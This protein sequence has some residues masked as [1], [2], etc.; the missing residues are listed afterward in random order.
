VTARL[1]LEDVSFAY[2]AEPVLRGVT[3]EV[4]PAA[5][6]A[7]VGPNGAGKTT[8]LKIAAGLLRPTSGRVV[9]ETRAGGIAYLAQAEPLPGSFTTREIVEL[10]RFPHTGLLRRLSRADHA[11]VGAA[12]ELTGTT[13]L[14]ERDVGTLSGGEQQ[15]VAL[16]RALAQEPEVLL[17]DE[18]TNHL[19]PRHQIELF[20]ALRAAATRGVAVVAVL[21]DLAFAS[22]VDRCLLLASGALVAE[23]PPADVLRAERLSQVYGATIEVITS[24]TGRLVPVPSLR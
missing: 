11:A 8:L 22:A 24:P 23:G 14:A 19:D 15:R 9:V 16:A 7:I 21:H 17:L 3:F 1:G 4:A 13:A 12:L 2:E 5:I 18:P 10:G 6:T 20:K